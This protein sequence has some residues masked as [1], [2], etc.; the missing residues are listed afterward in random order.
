MPILVLPSRQ[1]G[2]GYNKMFDPKYFCCGLILF[3]KNRQ[4]HSSAI[5]RVDNL[6]RLIRNSK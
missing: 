3:S 5:D 2:L 1:G 4:G 6:P